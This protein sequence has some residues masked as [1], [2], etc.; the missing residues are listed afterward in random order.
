MSSEGSRTAVEQ[1]GR[2]PSIFF[3]GEQGKSTKKCCRSTTRGW[4]EWRRRC[5]RADRTNRCRVN[6]DTHR[7]SC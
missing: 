7:A 4:T 2:L 6:R 5:Q 1:A 3:L